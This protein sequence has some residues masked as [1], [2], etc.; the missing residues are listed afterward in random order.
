MRS[1]DVDQPRLRRVEDLILEKRDPF[2]A[3]PGVQDRIFRRIRPVPGPARPILKFSTVAAANRKCESLKVP[4]VGTA[5]A[6]LRQSPSIEKTPP[7]HREPLRFAAATL[8]N[9]REGSV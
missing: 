8:E 9:G 4:R 6:D 1:G 3:V 7:A 5:W 2:R